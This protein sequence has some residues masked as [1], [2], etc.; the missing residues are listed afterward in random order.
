MFFIFFIFRTS[1]WFDGCR[2]LL[3][4]VCG[5]NWLT[6]IREDNYAARWFCWISHLKCLSHKTIK[7]IERR[8]SRLDLI[9]IVMSW[10]IREGDYACFFGM[11]THLFWFFCEIYNKEKSK[12][13]PLNFLLWYKKLHLTVQE[14]YMVCKKSADSDKENSNYKFLKKVI[15]IEIHLDVDNCSAT[16]TR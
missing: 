12:N 10:W 11:S 4:R 16:I 9:A 13:S 1:F 15:S 5:E 8:L 3:Y 7:K 6:V 2:R 14:K